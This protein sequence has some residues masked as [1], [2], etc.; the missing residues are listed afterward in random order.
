MV[1]CCNGIRFQIAVW[2]MFLP[3]QL[4]H[5]KMV[6]SRI[7][8]RARAFNWLTQKARHSE[9]RQAEVSGSAGAAVVAC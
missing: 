2:G 6:R 1:A 5:A 9:A 8:A 4:G 7:I 3:V